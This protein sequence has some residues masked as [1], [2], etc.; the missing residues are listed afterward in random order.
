MLE[1]MKILSIHNKELTTKLE[2]IGSTPGASLV[3][4]SEMIKKDASTSCLYLIDDS[5]S[6]NQVLGENIVIETCFDEIALEN[7]LLKHEVARFGKAL[8]DKKGKAIQTQPPRDNTTTR[9]NKPMEGEIVVCW[10]CHKESHT[11]YQCKP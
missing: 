9:V 10:L 3:E 2:N 7:E 6:C 1:K 5:N 11:S 4:I 8:Y